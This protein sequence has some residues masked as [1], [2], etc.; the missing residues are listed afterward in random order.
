KYDAVGG[1]AT[2]FASEIGTFLSGFD[3][4]HTSNESS[5]TDFTSY[6]NICSKKG[7]INTLLA[8]GLDIVELTGNHNQDCGDVAA[9][10]TIDIY[11][12]NNIKIVG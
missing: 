12:A 8:I 1:D 3:L 9:T 11:N 4:T 7:F 6:D 5:F 2:Y 10:E